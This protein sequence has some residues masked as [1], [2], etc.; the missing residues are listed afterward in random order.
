MKAKRAAENESLP[1][2]GFV[3][4]GNMGRPIAKRLVDAG[5]RVTV[6]DISHDAVAAAVDDGAA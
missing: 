2:I 1:S 3:G 4:L 5:Y 6:F